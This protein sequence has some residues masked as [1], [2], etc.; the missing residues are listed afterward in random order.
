MSHIKHLHYSTR[1][2]TVM[3]KFTIS[4]LR[5]TLF[6]TMYVVMGLSTPCILRNIFGKDLPWFYGAAGAVGGSMV[7]IEAPSRQLGKA[8]RKPY[9]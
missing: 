4:C 6:L 1:P 5:S 9:E 7:I 2:K 3:Q 8:C